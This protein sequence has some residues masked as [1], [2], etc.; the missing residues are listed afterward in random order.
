MQVYDSTSPGILTINIKM[1]W[2]RSS[3]TGK[4]SFDYEPLVLK[5]IK[6]V[7]FFVLTQ[8]LLDLFF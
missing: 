4:E 8:I 7:K 3:R 6:L 1:A 5:N 2:Y